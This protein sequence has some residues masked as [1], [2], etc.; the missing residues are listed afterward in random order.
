MKKFEYVEPDSVEE[1]LKILQPI[2]SKRQ[3]FGRGRRSI[4]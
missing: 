3:G 2:P 1:V 4:T